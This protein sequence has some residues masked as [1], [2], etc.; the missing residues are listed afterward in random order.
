MGLT[1]TDNMNSGSKCN[2]KIVSSLVHFRDARGPLPFSDELATKV[3]EVM[4][5]KNAG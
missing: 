2:S 5:I 1:Q 4:R 3:L